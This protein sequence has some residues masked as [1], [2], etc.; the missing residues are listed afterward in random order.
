MNLV[1]HL[2]TLADELVTFSALLEEEATILAANQ[3]DAL[4]PLIARRDTANRRI[5]G[6]WQGLTGSLGLPATTGLDALRQHCQDAAPEAWR[7][8]ETLAHQAE[9]LNRINSRIID[10]QL[11]HTQAAMQVLRN[12]A[13]SR[14]P[15]G[16][17]GRVS[18]FLNPNRS[19][20]TA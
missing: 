4:A 2:D 8:M 14:A 11:R 15:Y 17:D 18:D 19:I 9:R 7:R 6:R 13:G 10:E 16:A 12:A 3:A 5:A 1:S 20:D